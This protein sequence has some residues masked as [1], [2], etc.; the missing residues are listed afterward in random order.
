MIIRIMGEGQY[1]VADG[2]VVDLQELDVALEKAVDGNDD[3][4]FR[5][6]LNSLLDRVREVGRPLPDDELDAS[7]AILPS[8]DAHVDEVR[9]LL[10]GDGVIPG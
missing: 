4:D 10:L 8:E 6:A 2:D 5:R 1:D 3:G 7:D 9:A